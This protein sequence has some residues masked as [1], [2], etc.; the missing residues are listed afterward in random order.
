M[1][2]KK[3]AAVE[4]RRREQ[5]LERQIGIHGLPVSKRVCAACLSGGPKQIIAY[6]WAY[7]ETGFE[8][9]QN[10][11]LCSLD[12]EASARALLAVIAM[13]DMGADHIDMNVAYLNAKV[14]EILYMQRPPGY[15]AKGTV[16]LL[17]LSLYGLK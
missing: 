15:E 12:G 9:P 3:V 16:C 4:N 11:W 13:L 10:H 7:E 8:S 6:E 14:K 5:T 1:S 17:L 2:R